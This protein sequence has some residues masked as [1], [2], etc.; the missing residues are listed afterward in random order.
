MKDGGFVDIG[1]IS[2][3]VIL[4][5]IPSVLLCL[6]V[7]EKDV[8]EKEPVM[9]LLRLFFLGVLITVPT[10]FMERFILSIT[11]INEDNYFDC[12]IMAFF[13]VAI[14]EEGLKYLIFYSR[15]FI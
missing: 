3:N 9:M 11:K 15:I 4:A 6:Y 1:L 8:V 10:F 2:V 5:I 13:I 7:Y 14:I 12:F